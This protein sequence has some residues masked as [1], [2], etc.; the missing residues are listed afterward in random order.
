M[1]R[2]DLESRFG[3]LT[4][5]DSGLANVDRDALTHGC[6]GVCQI[7]EIG[8]ECY[9]ELKFDVSGESSRDATA[10]PNCD[11]CGVFLG[12]RLNIEQKAFLPAIL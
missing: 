12:W 3:K 2:I 1:D 10:G 4:G 6:R 5:L 7:A 8:K 9:G 11:G